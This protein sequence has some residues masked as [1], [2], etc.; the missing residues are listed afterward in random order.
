MSKG[1]IESVGLV[2]IVIILV[3][4][5]VFTIPFLTDDSDIQSLNEQYLTLKAD[6]T[7]SVL[8]S[9]TLE[10]CQKTIKEE[11]SSCLTYQETSCFTSCDE[12]QV[13]IDQ[14]LTSSMPKNTYYNVLVGNN[15]QLT[16]SKG[17]CLNTI[18]SSKH[19]IN[20]ETPI[21]I[22]LCS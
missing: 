8:L 10:N 5:V 2:I 18:T 19:F 3:L 6:N 14:I 22:S 21:Q 20:Q 16:I 9:T 1:Q 15:K 11:L 13:T 7:I 4:A 12:L 17:S